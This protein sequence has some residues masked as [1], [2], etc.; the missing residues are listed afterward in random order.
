MGAKIPAAL[1]LC[2]GHERNKSDGGEFVL[3]PDSTRE[4]LLVS[5]PLG[6]QEK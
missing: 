1:G 6:L 2:E 4:A 5:P 3:Q